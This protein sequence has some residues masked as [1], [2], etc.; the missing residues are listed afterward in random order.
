[1]LRRTAARQ[2]AEIDEL[3]AQIAGLR[4]Q[5]LGLDVAPVD[6]AGNG[7]T[8]PAKAIRRIADV[9]VVGSRVVSDEIRRAVNELAPSQFFNVY[10]PNPGKDAPTSVF[11]PQFAPVNDQS[12]AKLAEYRKPE[13]YVPG[14]W[15]AALDAAVK[16]RPDLIWLVGP[17]RGSDEEE[18][19]RELQKRPALARIRVNTVRP[20]DLADP[21][22]PQAD[23]MAQVVDRR[24]RR[25]ADR[26]HHDSRRSLLGQ[27]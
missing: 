16:S 12:K 10:T 11:A 18:L 20:V 8:Q 23:R 13:Q 15:L 26:M 27:V 22:V 7:T 19:M 6:N 1:M 2:R 14:S 25:M 4:E 5:L 17:L 21:A 3:K 9:R 24:P